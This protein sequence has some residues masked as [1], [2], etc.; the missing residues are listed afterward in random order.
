MAERKVGVVI[1]WQNL[2]PV[3]SIFRLTPEL[4]SKFPDYLA[5]QY[6]A[7]RREDCRLT[8]KVIGPD[9]KVDYVPDLDESGNQKRGPITHSY[10]ISSA[11]FET[12]RMGYLEC[13]VI[14]EIDEAGQPGRLTESLF[15]I[16]PKGD[17]KLTYFYRITGDFTLEKRA[18][19]FR[20]V[21]LV[22]TGTGLAPFASMIKQLHFEYSHGRSNETKYTLIHTNRT[23]PELAY[24]DQLLAIEASQKFDFVYIPTVS[25]PAPEDF[26]NPKIGTGRANNLLRTIF[27]MPLKEEQTLQ[28]AIS[29]GEDTSMARVALEKTVKPV[30]PPHLS[31]KE[32]QKRLHPPETV[33]LNCGNPLAMAD[34]EYIARV[35]HIQFEK[36][37]W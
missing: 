19:G 4:G 3:L 22:G 34:I 37:E 16:D 31:R 6:I 35:N 1:Y 5:G 11:P 2:S 30:L 23:Y 14:L 25:R 13:Y 27:E 7:L 15:R 36:E 17:N 10:S 9:G 26:T 24:H 18:S 8:K 32:L 28:E 21:L 12:Q 33:I 29:R 20:S